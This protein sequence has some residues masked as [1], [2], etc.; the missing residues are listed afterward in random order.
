MYRDIG[1]AAKALEGINKSLAII[2]EAVAN[3][4]AASTTTPQGGTAS[5][6]NAG[7]P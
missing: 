7:N 2:A 5:G 4:Y 3:S 6:N 1:K